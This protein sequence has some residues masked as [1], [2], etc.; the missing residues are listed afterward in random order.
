MR[1]SFR[2]IWRTPSRLLPRKNSLSAKCGFKQGR[3]FCARTNQKYAVASDEN[4]DALKLK[5]VMKESI[6]APRVLVGWVESS[7]PTRSCEVRPGAG[8]FRRLHPPYKIS[9]QFLEPV[10]QI[11]LVLARQ[12]AFDELAMEGRGALAAQ[13]GGL[14]AREALVRV[15]G[16]Q[17]VAD[18]HEQVVGHDLR[19][20][21][22][23]EP[24]LELQLRFQERAAFIDPLERALAGQHF[25]QDVAQAGKV[26]VGR[27]LAASQ[28]FRRRVRRRP[29]APPPR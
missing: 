4:N 10:A 25:Y 17:L 27:G 3:S 13:V 21:D 8:G 18:V 29:H 2:P 23:L 5:K 26:G 14:G 7:E 15:G 22:L 12:V 19:R 9:I 20:Q 24:L 1:P 16:G 6:P 28:N 11:V